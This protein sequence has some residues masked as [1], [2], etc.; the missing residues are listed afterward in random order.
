MKPKTIKVS[1]EKL[2]LVWSGGNESAIGLK[3]LREECPC[4]GCKGETI[5][6]H[7]YRPPKL[8]LLHPDMYTISGASM[9]GEYALQIF[10]KDGHNSGIYTWE[11]LKTL[12][13]NE[14]TNTKQTYDP[15]L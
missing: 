13:E 6:L 7:T 8:P 2:T 10:W 3:Y 15:L 12:V 14:S 1:K 11:Y 9:V 4:A 5:L